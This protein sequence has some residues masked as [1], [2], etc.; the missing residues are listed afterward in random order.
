MQ[1]MSETARPSG[2]SEGGLHVRMVLAVDP[3]KLSGIT[4]VS[5]EDENVEVE[6]SG[7]C[8][9]RHFHEPILE[10]IK[11]AAIRGVRLDVV[12]ERFIINAQ[13]AKNSQAPFSLEQIG[14]L[15]YILL[16]A[17]IDPDEIK[18]QSPVDAKKMFPN[19]A[20]KKIGVWHRGGQGHALDAMR[21][22]MLFLVKNGWKPVRL[23]Q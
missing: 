22:A 15:K 7:E 1:K 17:G 12:C 18:F 19:D 11:T 2:R 9:A 14:V 10:A 3:G 5:F 8:D 20:L 13:T 6:Y 23:L 21:H 16:T 4:I